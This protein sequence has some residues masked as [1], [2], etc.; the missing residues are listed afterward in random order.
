MPN[1]AFSFCVFYEKDDIGSA[2]YR[3]AKGI[4][5]FQ[6]KEDSKTD[7][8]DDIDN[9][10]IIRSANNSD[11]D[12]FIYMFY[13]FI[14]TSTSIQQKLKDINSSLLEVLGKRCRAHDLRDLR[15]DDWDYRFWMFK[16]KIRWSG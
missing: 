8:E 6:T 16:E 1:V 5:N 2:W 10:L 3:T 7:P 9:D 12:D 15:D 4:A 13:S 14:T 11:N